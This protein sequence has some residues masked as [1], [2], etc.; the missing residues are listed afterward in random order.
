MS[1]KGGCSEDSYCSSGCKSHRQRIP[2]A[3]VVISSGRKGDRSV[4]SLDVKVRWG[5]AYVWSDPSK[6]GEQ[7]V[8]SQ[9]KRTCQPRKTLLHG[10]RM[11]RDVGNA[12][13]V[14]HGRRPVLRWESWK[15]PT[16]ESPGYLRAT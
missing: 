14:P 7:T 3:A 10:K 12:E 5:Q 16:V 6:A 4:E 13:P 9:R 8:R 1:R 15:V 2:D 11:V